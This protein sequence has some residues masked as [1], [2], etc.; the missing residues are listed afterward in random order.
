MSKSF[1]IGRHSSRSSALPADEVRARLDEDPALPHA[2]GLQR[3]RELAA[4]LGVVPEEVVGDEEGV[5]RLL[6]VVDDGADG[7]LAER[8]AVE[9]PD[10]A[11]AAAERAAARGLDQPDGLEEQA[12]VAVAVPLHEVA[13]GQR[14][15]VEPGPLSSGRVETQPSRVLSRSA[16]TSASGRP[17]CQR[18]GHSW[19]DLFA[20]VDA[21]GVDLGRFERPREGRGRMPA[22]EDE[23]IGDDA[24]NLPA[25]SR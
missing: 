14:D 6:E 22:D 1:A 18:V 19:H 9:L 11:E 7:A 8:P 21:D 16:G 5:A 3:A 4:A 10:R 17:R 15:L 23:R 2:P 13:G 20:V 24:A 12:V 25:P